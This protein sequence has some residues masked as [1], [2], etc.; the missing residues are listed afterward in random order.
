MIAAS[1]SSRH[2]ICFDSEK[3]TRESWLII[4]QL[5]T[6]VLRYP[7]AGGQRVRFENCRGNLWI[8]AGTTRIYFF[9]GG[10]RPRYFSRRGGGGPAPLLWGFIERVLSRSPSLALLAP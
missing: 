7:P 1:S 9:F 8:L 2:L 3:T 6:P 4:P 10:G 5:S